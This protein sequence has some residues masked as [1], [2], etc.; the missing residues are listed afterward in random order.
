MM[1]SASSEL[2]ALIAG[3][4]G[5][6]GLPPLS[7]AKEPPNN[8]P[9]TP[10][11]SCNNQSVS[12]CCPAPKNRSSSAGSGDFGRAGGEASIGVTDVVRGNLR[13]EDV[14][15]LDHVDERQGTEVG[16]VRWCSCRGWQTR[17]RD[18]VCLASKA[19]NVASRR[20]L[21]GKQPKFCQQPPKTEQADYLSRRGL[22]EPTPRSRSPDKDV[23][24]RKLWRLKPSNYV[25]K[26]ARSTIRSL[27]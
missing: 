22:A 7:M 15:L 8:V 23:L 4:A 26:L 14:V 11:A 13:A 10:I 24:S 17:G 6:L 1:K 5:V 21:S 16:G 12:Q 3:V 25:T 19:K 9:R 2:E 18:V 27:K 20:A